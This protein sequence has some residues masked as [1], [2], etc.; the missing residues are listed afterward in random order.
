MIYVRAQ[1]YNLPADILVDL[2]RRFFKSRIAS[3]DRM[4]EGYVCR[5]KNR[6]E[7]RQFDLP[8][9]LSRKMLLA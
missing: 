3:R 2:S 7:T 1:R 4:G 8:Q 5:V 9:S 6:I